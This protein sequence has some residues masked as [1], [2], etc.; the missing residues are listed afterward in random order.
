[1]F[2][3]PAR[4]KTFTVFAGSAEMRLVKGERAKTAKAKMLEFLIGERSISVA[5][6]ANGLP[7]FGDVMGRRR[8]INGSL[9][10]LEAGTDQSMVR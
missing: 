6:F 2:D 1:M 5:G 9:V 7:W 10:S 8:T 3:C 4:T